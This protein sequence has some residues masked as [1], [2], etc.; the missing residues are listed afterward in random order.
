MAQFR[1]TQ[2]SESAAA[3]I[4]QGEL[5]LAQIGERVGVDRR[6]LY[7]WRNDPIFHARVD[8]ETERYRSEVNR[9]GLAKMECRLNALNDRWMAL[10]RVIIDRGLDP[11]IQGVPGGSTGLLVKQVKGVGR[12]ENFELVTTYRLDVGLLRSL[13]DLEKQAAQELGQWT[14]RTEGAIKP[15][16][17]DQA[18]LDRAINA[19]AHPPVQNQAVTGKFDN[20]PDSQLP[21]GI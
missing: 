7:E 3:L 18:A 9:I 14:N 15:V 21:I 20:R 5:R 17:V 10:Q 19:A 11:E 2:K 8:E 4:V 1:W 13:L 16:H 12:G 6:T